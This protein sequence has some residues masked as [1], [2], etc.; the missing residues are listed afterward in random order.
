M[1]PTGIWE[2]LKDQG[3]VVFILGVI[4]FYG[5]RFIKAQIDAQNQ[6]ETAREQRYNQLVD[7]TLANAAQNSKAILD[8]VASNTAAWQR[9]ESKLD[10]GK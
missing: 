10:G 5:A 6:R 8:V 7:A 1:E 4:V 3:P 9:V 2:V